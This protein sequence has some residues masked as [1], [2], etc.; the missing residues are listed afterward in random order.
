MEHLTGLFG[1]RSG[2]G[3]IAEGS[4][5]AVMVPAAVP[6]AVVFVFNLPPLP[7]PPYGGVHD[8]GLDHLLER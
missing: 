3:G 6:A 8:N 1:G 7:L 4:T 5:T 2:S